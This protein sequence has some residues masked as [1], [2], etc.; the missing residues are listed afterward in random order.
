MISPVPA[1]VM[2][3]QMHSRVPR[4]NTFQEDF[5]STFRYFLCAFGV[6][7]VVRALTFHNNNTPGKYKLRRVGLDFDCFSRC[8][9]LNFGHHYSWPLEIEIVRS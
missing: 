5:T 3:L 2:W 4:L 1:Q 6:K 8:S 9:N 7:R